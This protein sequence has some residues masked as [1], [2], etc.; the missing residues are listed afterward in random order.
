MCPPEEA[1][2][3][4]RTATT[5]PCRER[6]FPVELAHQV[7]RLLDVAA[8]RGAEDDRL[9]PRLPADVFER[10]LG[11]DRSAGED[12]HGDRAEAPLAD[13]LLVQLHS[14]AH[15]EVDLVDVAADDRV[16]DPQLLEHV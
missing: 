13:R 1:I 3:M 2:S 4:R 12:A 9:D 16:L 8:R 10:L 7:A 15:A 14:A 5:L 6:V 11:R